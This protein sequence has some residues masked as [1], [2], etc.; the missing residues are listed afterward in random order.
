MSGF[1]PE[2]GDNMGKVADNVERKIEHLETKHRFLSNAVAALE[3]RT[4]LS[5]DDQQRVH[6]LKKE[7][8]AAKDALSGLRRG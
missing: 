6:Q 7:K 4:H 8:L 5:E 3:S 2:T 1:E